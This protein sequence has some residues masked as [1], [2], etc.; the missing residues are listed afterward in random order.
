MCDSSVQF[1]VDLDVIFYL[2]EQV[3]WILHAPIRVG[4]QKIAG[5]SKAAGLDVDRHR[6][7]NRMRCTVNGEQARNLDLGISCLRYSAG[8]V[9]RREH[10][11][12]IA[13]TFKNLLVHT[14]VPSVAATLATRRVYHDLPSGLTTLS[15]EGDATT[16]DAERAMYCMERTRE[17]ER[18]LAVRRIDFVD[19][20]RLVSRDGEGQRD[21]KRNNLQNARCEG[22]MSLPRIVNISHD[23]HR[24]GSDSGSK[25]R[26]GY[27]AP[28]LLGCRAKIDNRAE[29]VVS[30]L[31][32]PCTSQESPFRVRNGNNGCNQSR[33]GA[34][35]YGFIT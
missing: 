7:G 29:L 16:F 19:E 21:I 28:A 3:T 6:R 32:F 27:Y 8:D 33:N 15:I 10:D 30:Y 4:N 23:E 17:S 31:K 34:M 5:G 2:E 26:C 12:G 14:P 20:Y 13:L 9:G 35:F 22:N 1:Q 11:F 24:L 25:P 18:N